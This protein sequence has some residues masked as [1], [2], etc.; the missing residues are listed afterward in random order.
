M[1]SNLNKSI[2]NFYLNSPLALSLSSSM[3]EISQNDLRVSIIIGSFTIVVI[4]LISNKY[5]S[6]CELK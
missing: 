6:R 1:L 2:L 5:F 3:P 4:Y